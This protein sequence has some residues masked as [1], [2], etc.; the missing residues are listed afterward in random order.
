MVHDSRASPCRP[1]PAITL[2]ID[3]PNRPATMSLSTPNVND[4]EHAASLL[5][6]GGDGDIEAGHHQK[7]AAMRIHPPDRV[8]GAH[9][10]ILGPDED[11]A[12]GRLQDDPASLCLVGGLKAR[13]AVFCRAEGAAHGRSTAYRAAFAG[14]WLLL[15]SAALPLLLNDGSWFRSFHIVA[16]AGISAAV[17]LA[18]KG[19]HRASAL[20]RASERDFR[21][22]WDRSGLEGELAAALA[23]CGHSLAVDRGDRVWKVSVFRREREVGELPPAGAID[24]HTRKLFGFCERIGMIERVGMIER[25]R[26]DAEPSSSADA[27]DSPSPLDLWTMNGLFLGHQLNNLELTARSRRFGSAPALCFLF[28]WPFIPL[29]LHNLTESFLITILAVAAIVL[30]EFVV[31][32]A[33]LQTVREYVDMPHVHAANEAMAR[34]LAPLYRDRHNGL[35]L[36]Y[37]VRPLTGRRGCTYWKRG[38][39][40]LTEPARAQGHYASFNT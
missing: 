39:F 12:H 27:D 18:A 19:A 24:E 15:F 31:F 23:G 4:E 37:Y 6:G 14:G 3:T 13:I 5:G 22:A 20:Y 29:A 36:A 35:V 8:V 9:C 26:D 33:A 38:T 40:T 2:R 1:L 25:G 11:G 16:W 10:V 17:V 28:T 34:R 21:A 30:V 32:V 7:I